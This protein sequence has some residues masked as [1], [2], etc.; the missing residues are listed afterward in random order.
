VHPLRRNNGP[1][2]TQSS[3]SDIVCEVQHLILQSNTQPR[4]SS[5]LSGTI[6]GLSGS[7][8]SCSVSVLIG[9]VWAVDGDFDGDLTALDLLSVHF[10]HS[11]L[12]LFLGGK[13]NEAEA[14]TLA[15]L[16]AS[17]KL[18]D[19]E[20][21]DWSKGDLGRGWLIGSEEFLEL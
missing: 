14:T 13:S 3:A 18:L 19:H 4:L 12:L 20:T 16:I 10:I 6:G 17:L 2:V 9:L 21:R 1:K 7:L 8:S 15:G 5:S 11:L